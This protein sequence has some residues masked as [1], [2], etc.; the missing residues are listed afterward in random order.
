MPITIKHNVT[1]DFSHR[2]PR[3]T[4]P[5][6]RG[7]KAAHEISFILR[8]EADYI[9]LAEKT[10]AY[11]VVQNGVES[12]YVDSSGSTKTGT[13]VVDACIVNYD[14][15][16]ISWQVAVDALSV[17]GEFPVILILV[18]ENGANV[19]SCVFYFAVSETGMIDIEK[20][21]DAALKASSAWDLIAKVV[22]DADL[23][24]TIEER[25]MLNNISMTLTVKEGEEIVFDIGTPY[26][27]D[28]GDGSEREYWR[29]SEVAATVAHTYDT[30]GTYRCIIYGLRSI[31]VDAF[32]GASSI[33]KLFVGNGV[34]SIGN[35][36]FRNCPNLTE[37]VISDGV[38]YIGE[39]AFSGCVKLEKI[40]FGDSVSEIGEFALANTALGHIELPDSLRI[41]PAGLFSSNQNLSSVSFGKYVATVGSWTSCPDL[42]TVTF[43]GVIPPVISTAVFTEV[44][45]LLVRRECY[46][47]Y[48]ALYSDIA[49]KIKTFATTAEV[50]AVQTELITHKTDPAAHEDIRRT[51][52]AAL[53][54]IN[55][56]LTGITD[57]TRDQLFEVLD[58][59]TKHEGD[60]TKA[61]ATKVKYD[62]IVDNLESSDSKLVLSANQGRVLKAFI[63]ALDKGKLSTSEL[64]NAINTALAQAKESGKFDGEGGDPGRDT[65][66][67]SEFVD[68][69]SGISV[70]NKHQLATSLVNRVPLVDENLLIIGLYSDDVF[71][72]MAKVTAIGSSTFTYKIT[73]FVQINGRGIQDISFVDDEENSQRQ[74]VVEYTD[75]S[76]KNDLTIP[77]GK[78][79][80]TPY[81]KDGYWWIGEE[82]LGVPATAGVWYGTRAEFDEQYAAGLIPIGSFVIIKEED[83]STTTAVLGKAILGKM[84]LGRSN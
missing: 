13:G 11:I 79:G 31:P 73:D 59:I 51:A 14:K 34:S 25:V 10:R 4:I 68:F 27:V 23:I 32:I 80:D 75:G 71:K 33:V 3:V 7:D 72:V 50:A 64:T 15:Q 40:T 46:E 22:N 58:L 9:E 18:D 21:I 66:M 30:A 6:S 24:K 49:G 38:Q 1:L 5:F 70:G 45:T 29:G 44:E 83:G 84:I 63:D 74:V 37:V 41:I 17:S 69:P 53:E 48:R 20:E 42:K 65:L 16:V 78:D 60:V 77:N 39:E 19:G 81:I 8:Y 12:Q 82:S 61:L 67:V 55:T 35:S 52:N 2:S 47:S 62:D 28:W 76:V 43:R 56:F 36:A 26:S 57:E 54:K